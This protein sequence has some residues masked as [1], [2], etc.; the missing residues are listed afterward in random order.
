MA[1]NTAILQSSRAMSPPLTVCQAKAAL[2]LWHS[3]HFD[4]FDIAAVLHVREDS[5]CRTVQAAR[6][7]QRGAAS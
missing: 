2:V 3:G 5:V 4:S 7:L 6:D 1:Q